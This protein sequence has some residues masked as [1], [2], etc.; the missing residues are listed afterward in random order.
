MKS[1]IPFV[2]RFLFLS[3][4]AAAAPAL[5]EETD[6]TIGPDYTDAP[7]TKVR[8]GVPTGEVHQFV[9]ESKDS[10]IYPGIAKKQPGVVPYQRKVAVYVPA[11][12]R[13]TKEMPFIIVQDGMGYK[14]LMTRVLDNMI[15]EKRLPAMVAV[16]ISSGG[17][18]SKGSQRGLEYDTVSGTY[19][20][21][22]EQEVLPKISKDHKI[23]FTTNPEGRAT[24]G[25]SSGGAAA[26]TMAWFH[27]ELYRRV[28]TY[29]GT[30]V[31]QQFPE[32][33]ESPNGAWEYHEKL[34]PAAERKPLRVWLEVSE[35]DNGWDK[36]EK[37][38]HNWVLANQRMAAA[39][40]AKGYACR[41]VFAANAGHVDRKVTRQTLPAALEWLWQ[42]YPGTR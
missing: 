17:G 30:Y 11:G 40:K 27:P 4:L 16:F 35:K 24:M 23:R 34:I 42:G 15:A 5:A 7:E 32:N 10:A 29:S 38:H 28:L 36:E 31:D 1:P 8:P 18:D 37:T 2:R 19:T 25:G 6:F 21:F 20:R 22:I 33:P 39:L 14:D 13:P 26:F 41:Y 9:M 12:H 3:V